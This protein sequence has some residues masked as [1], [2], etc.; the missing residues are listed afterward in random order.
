M[1]KNPAMQQSFKP[2]DLAS[3]F[4]SKADL[5]KYF[6]EHRKCPPSC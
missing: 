1:V 6:C 4:S 5:I 2:G 3:K